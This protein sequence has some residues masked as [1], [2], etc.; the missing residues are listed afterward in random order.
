MK[1]LYA[2][3]M[4]VSVLMTGTMAQETKKKAPISV[5]TQM[6]LN[7]IE[8]KN[9]R[10]DERNGKPA[11]AENARL[12]VS[13]ESDM[14]AKKVAEQIRALGVQ[15][16]AVV[17]RH[18]MLS[19][20][21]E[22][23]EKMAEIEGVTYISMGSKPRKRTDVSRVVTG[24]DS[25]LNAVEPLPQAFTGKDVVVG[26]LD[27]GFDYTHPAFK[28]ADGNLRIKSVFIP[29]INRDEDDEPVVVDDSIVLDGVA[30]N[31]PEQI[32][33]LKKDYSYD[34]HGS[35][36]ASIAAG[37]KYQN[38]GGMAPE[39][40]IVLCPIFDGGFNDHTPI[41]YGIMYV[42]DYARRQGKPYVISMSINGHCGP[43]DGTGVVP[44]M[45]ETLAQEGVNMVVAA[46]NEG[47]YPSYL[48][49]EFAEADTMHTINMGQ[50]MNYAF[51]RQPC[52]MS[53]QIGLY[54]LTKRQEVWRSKAMSNIDGE[55]GFYIVCR[56][57]MLV[58]ENIVQMPD[59]VMRDFI[60]HIQPIFN[61]AMQVNIDFLEDG[62]SQVSFECDSQMDN[63]YFTLHITCPEGNI[64]DMWG[65]YGSG[66]YDVSTTDY[67]IRGVN[68]MSFG[69][70]TTGGSTVDVG[71][72][73]A[74]STYTNID[75]N[76]YPNEMNEPAGKYTVFSSFGPDL[77]GHQHPFISAPGSTI[78]SA[79]S[80]FD[81]YYKSDKR[82]VVAKDEN[83]Y[84]WGVMSGTSMATP[85][86]AGIMALWL[87]A[88][89]DAT[90]Q[91]LKDAMA[92]SANTD[93]WTEAAPE[94]FGH[95]KIN[96]YRGLLH[97]LGITTAIPTLSQHQPKGVSF[98]LREGRL[99]M[100]GAAE[101]TPVRIYT[102]DGRMVSS[103]AV[104]NGSVVLPVQAG[105]YAVQVG[106]LG[107]TLI[108]K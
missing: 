77:A 78:A 43:H 6:Y 13:C 21:V 7:Q 94:H 18:I 17:G 73:T 51:S 104:S 47:D 63:Y 107:S 59:S 82:Y 108:R 36:C 54:D 30:Y 42:R 95:G 20:P 85:T 31:T 19:T 22:L 16:Q 24:V 29:G 62:R 3:L 103:S 91:E 53:F 79:L 100:D 35:H 57:G 12:Y 105:I 72:W 99:Y 26:V 93:E 92:Q 58:G 38:Y 44:E 101:G 5:R 45:Y 56:N 48:N 49:Y 74:R 65:D 10:V 40:D 60:D 70:Y 71:S 98:R 4:I 69:D 90:Y 83:G 97:L 9:H 2:V 23:V 15:P 67:Y 28:D 81:S 55:K 84:Q 34:S 50:P 68:N 39:A 33:N 96:A 75:G 52:E 66:F 106:T 89:P 41:M 102:T 27:G 25:I 87:Q 1:R 64:L 14:T 32:L 76:E 11:K 61:G 86:V 80:S 8:T 37:S 46:S 88:K